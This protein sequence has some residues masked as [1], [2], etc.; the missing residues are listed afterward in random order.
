MRPTVYYTLSDIGDLCRDT[1]ASVSSLR[2]HFRGEV[3]LDV[4]P[5]NPGADWISL[6]QDHRVT[7]QYRENETQAW[8]IKQYGRLGRYGE[9]VATLARAPEDLVLFLDCD[10]RIKAR[11]D[12]IFQEHCFDFS[13]RIAPSM[14]ALDWVKYERYFWDHNTNR[15]KP[16]YNAGVLAFKNGMARIIGSEALKILKHYTFLPRAGPQ[17]QKDQFSIS[18]ALALGDYKIRPMGPEIHGF[19]WLN[20]SNKC[21][22]YHGTRRPGREAIRSFRGWLNHVS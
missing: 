16:V 1:L 3:I 9:K 21:T 14:L 10:T 4:T 5:P 15:I 18:V 2:K 8:R 20:E 11:I 22:V 12:P 6:I 13:A 7:I 19:R 17:L